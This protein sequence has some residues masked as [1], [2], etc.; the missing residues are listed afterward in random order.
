MAD[1][2]PAAKGP[3]SKGYA[4]GLPPLPAIAFSATSL[5][6]TSEARGATHHREDWR[7]TILEDAIL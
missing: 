2:D 7:R 5:A 4:M 1:D 6:G 3:V